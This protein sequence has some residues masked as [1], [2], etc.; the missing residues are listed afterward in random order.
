MAFDAGTNLFVPCILALMTGKNRYLYRTF[1]HE[2][3]VVLNY[4]WMPRMIILDIEKALLSAVQY[5]FSESN[6]VG[7]HFHFK[8][9]L[10]RKMIKFALPQNVCSAI[11]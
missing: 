4:K 7:C 5:E 1:F 11:I 8:P 6:I 9:A 2:V 3:I 10:R